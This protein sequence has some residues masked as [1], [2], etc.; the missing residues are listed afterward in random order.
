MSPS[1]LLETRILGP[2]RTM[3]GNGEPELVPQSRLSGPMPW[4]IAIMVAMTVIAMAAGLALRNTVVSAQAGLEGG[5]TV[6]I[7]EARPAE[8]DAQTRAAMERLRGLSGVSAVR[9]VPSEEIDRLIEP[10]LGSDAVGAKAM[11]VPIPSLIDV[12]LAGRADERQVGAVRAALA[13]VAPAA[14]VDAQSGWLKPVYGAI[15][16]LQWLAIALVVLLAMALAAAVLMAARTALGANRE[17]IEIVHL[18]GGTDAQ[19]ARVFQ[20]SIGIDAA[21]GGVVGFALALVVILLLGRRFAGLGAGLVEQGALGWSDW[22]LLAMVPV[23][24]ALLAML[25]ARL[26]VMHAV[27]K[28]V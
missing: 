21:G 8:R 6:Q 23:A 26:T 12:Q 11:A 17:T 10:W 27:R 24:A 16:S 3:A 9:L 19:I 25:T 1:E 22:I 7:V 13:P 5:L 18:L 15:A 2:V 20:R 14:R 4:V 28:M